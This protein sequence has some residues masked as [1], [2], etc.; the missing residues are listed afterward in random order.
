MPPGAL[1][2]TLP[3]IPPGPP[4]ERVSYR[5]TSG[6]CSPPPRRPRS[7][8]GT[9][10][11]TFSA[12]WWGRDLGSREPSEPERP[13]AA[14][15]PGAR[16]T[17]G[18]G[19]PRS[20]G[21]LGARESS[22]RG[23]CR[24]AGARLSLRVPRLRGSE[25]SASRGAECL[26][27]PRPAPPLIPPLARRAHEGQGAGLAGR[28]LGHRP[29]EVALPAGKARG[30][31][32]AEGVPGSRVRWGAGARSRAGGRPRALR[33]ACQAG[34]A[35]GGHVLP[36]VS[37]RPSAPPK[38]PGRRGAYRAARP[39]SRRFPARGWAGPSARRPP[40]CPPSHPRESGP[41]SLRGSERLRPSKNE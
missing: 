32:G 29:L 21:D 18:R 25:R 35:V 33:E 40:P 7:F 34:G 11:L 41:P 14:G 28:K 2:P 22:G 6:A 10:T 31:R 38:R 12:A 4:G 30:D 8:P 5:T 1:G 9:R 19:S 37:H 16:E 13:R 17:A 39:R 15:D 27:W 36:P 23:S 3:R 24:G 26:P 20:S